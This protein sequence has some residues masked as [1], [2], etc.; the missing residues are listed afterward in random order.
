MK[1]YVIEK[2]IE[3]AQL[4]YAFTANA[5]A[6]V[7]TS[8]QIL[9]DVYTAA[10]NFFDLLQVAGKYQVKPPHPYVAGCEFSGVVA[11]DSPIPKGCT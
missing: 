2:H 3:L 4:P 6:P 9:V 1:A 10:F 5:P 7:P 11:L 8:T